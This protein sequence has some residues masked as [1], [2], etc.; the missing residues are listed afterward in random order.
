MEENVELELE[1]QR[2]LEPPPSSP[3]EGEWGLGV[4]VRSGMEADYEWRGLVFMALLGLRGVDG[5]SG[6]VSRVLT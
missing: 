4:G 3:G 6:R 2:G 5:E 1:L